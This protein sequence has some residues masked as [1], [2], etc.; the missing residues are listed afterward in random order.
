MHKDCCIYP[1]DPWAADDDDGADGSV[2]D[3]SGGACAD[4]Y[5]GVAG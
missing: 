1:S 5:A 3:C 2:E 4:V